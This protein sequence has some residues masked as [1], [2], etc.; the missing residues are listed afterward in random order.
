MRKWSRQVKD[1]NG[2]ETWQEF[3]PY[4]YKE[5]KVNA[6]SPFKVKASEK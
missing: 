5:N 4:N 6:K 2:E 3:H 1:T